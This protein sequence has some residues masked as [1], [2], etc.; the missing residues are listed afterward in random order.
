MNWIYVHILINHF[1]VVLAGIAFLSVLV[2]MLI[3]KRQTWLYAAISLTLAG[4]FAYPTD[5]SGERAA[6][7][8]R[9]RMPSAREQIE[10]HEEAADVT[11][12]IL[13]GS[14]LL[15]MIGWYRIASDDPTATVP[16]WVKVALTVPALASGGAVAVTSV[17]GGHIGHQPWE[18]SLHAPPVMAVDSTIRLKETQPVPNVPSAIPPRDSTVPVTPPSH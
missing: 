8:F 7:I 5:V 2:A 12:W 4:V 10:S 6:R 13:L 17:R 11:L 16:G 15:G 14:G 9:Q 1:P 3:G 18:T